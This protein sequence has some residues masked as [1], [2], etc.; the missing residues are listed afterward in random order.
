ML[1]SRRFHHGPDREGNVRGPCDDRGRPRRNTVSAR[2]ISGNI[3]RHNDGRIAFIAPARGARLARPQPRRLMHHD[4]RMSANTTQ[5]P[6][7]SIHLPLYLA[8][9]LTMAAAVPDARAQSTADPV[10]YTLSF[11]E[12]QTHYVDVEAVLPTGRQPQV[13]VMMPVWTPGSY[14]V[15]EYARNVE[16]VAA[17]AADGRTLTVS[18]TRKNRW[19]VET[20]GASSV[21]LTYRV[22]AREL[23]VRTNWIDRQYAF[24]TGAATFITLTDVRTKRP[25]EVRLVL[26]AAWKTSMTGLP[27]APDGAPHHYVAADYDVLV[28]SPIIAGNPAIY[29]FDVDGKKHYLVNEGE[30]GMWDGA[31]AAKDVEKIVRAAAQVWGGTL[32]YDK[33]VFINVIGSQAGGGGLEHLNS[34]ALLT[35][36]FAMTTRR[37]YA[38]W[39]GLVSHEYFHLWNVKRLRPV[40][41]GP[42]D[43]ENEVYTTGLWVAEGITDYYADIVVRRAGL[44]ND[45]EYLGELSGLI[46]TLQTT[47]GRLEQPVA[48]ASYD[49]WIKQY[50]PDENSP[51]TAISYY[52]K[53]AVVGFLLDAKIRKATNGAKTLDDAMRLAYQR[54][55]GTRGYSAEEFR[56]AVEDTAGASFGDWWPRALNTTA[57]LDYAEALDWF[58][59]QFI[60]DDRRASRAWLGVTTKNDAGRLVITQVRRGT[61]GYAAGL[62]VDDEILAIGDIRVTAD[63]WTTR[64]DQYRPGQ[65]VSLLVARREILTRLD[66]TF[67]EEPADAWRLQVRPDATTDQQQHLKTFLTGAAT[68]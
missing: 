61:P 17:K 8:A 34:T 27:A 24:L 26:P 40:E 13:E 66:A 15:R 48:M 50:R 31:R 42:F 7:R 54:H 55:S 63:Q 41:L 25:H 43:Y 39:L 5:K 51:N 36:R 37:G 11:P 53:G 44:S 29:E 1:A 30:A 4:R 45:M 38:G 33:Y 2:H 62:N 19:R 28:D 56:K 10:R 35:G 49:A 23:S 14:L 22:Y 12:P 16:D 6:M 18:K 60:T 20:G 9:A 57:E 46:R 3:L 64:M 68:N 21:T 59:L 67:G 52:T 65:Q 58:G 32:P 47:P